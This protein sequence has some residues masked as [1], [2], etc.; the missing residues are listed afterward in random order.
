MKFLIDNILWIGLALISGGMLFWPALQTRG[1]K[2]S[3][4][5]AVQ[6]INAG[7]ILLVDVRDAAEFATGHLREARNIPSKELANRIGELEKLKSRNVIVMC[8]N[9]VQ[10]ARACGQFKA[11]GFAEVF[12]LEG[13]ISAWKE[14]GLPLAKD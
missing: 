10:S 14:Q 4:V 1:S 8:D 11:A 12:S 7:K 6:L 2:V 3:L 9:G 13:G 5:R